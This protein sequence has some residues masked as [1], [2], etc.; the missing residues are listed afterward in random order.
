VQH[1]TPT[2]PIHQA[3]CGL[4]M[5]ASRDI[6]AEPLPL[7]SPARSTMQSRARR[8]AAVDADAFARAHAGPGRPIASRCEPRTGEESS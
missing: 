3:G 2:L 5:P 4:Q 6:R 8:L 1:R 7:G